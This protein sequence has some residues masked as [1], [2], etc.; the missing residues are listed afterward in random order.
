[1]EV[2]HMA[3]QKYDYKQVRI[4]DLLLNTS[5]PRFNPVKHQTETIQAMVEDQQ[6]KLVR[7]Y[8]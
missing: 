4:T 8:H 7:T 5:N 2:F 6:G 1:M 3:G